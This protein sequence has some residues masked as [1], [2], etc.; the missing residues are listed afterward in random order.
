MCLV[1]YIPIASGYVISSNRDESPN[2]QETPLKKV[3]SNSQTL[4][5]PEDLKGG[6]WIATSDQMRSVCILNG[7]FIK[8]KRKPTYRLSRGIMLLEYFNHK[9]LAHFLSEFDLSDIE[10]FTLVIRESQALYELRWDGA[11]KHIERLSIS[12]VHIWS[13]ATLY[14]EMTI[15]LRK[16]MFTSMLEKQE[17]Y[18][19]PYIQ[20]VHLNGKIGDPAQDFVMN[21]DDR[22]ATISHSNLEVTDE[23]QVLYFKNLLTDKQSK[24]SI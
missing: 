17:D 2:R 19:L 21:R 8:H 18:T 6:T 5:Y 4:I 10:P 7:A 3:D 1:S 13:S 23:R 20:D 22:V 15:N 11:K 24:I 12:Q 16:S 9:N 14:D